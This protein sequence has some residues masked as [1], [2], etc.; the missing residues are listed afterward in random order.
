MK[1]SSFRAQSLGPITVSAGKP[2]VLF[3]YPADATPGC[4]KEACAFRDAWKSYE[5]RGVAIVGVSTDDVAAHARFAAE[6]HLPFPL[7]AD[8]DGA[9]ARAWGVGVTFGIAQRQTVLVDG[10]GVV[11]QTWADVDPGVHAAQILAA[12]PS[13][14]SPA[15][16]APPAPAPATVP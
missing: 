9:I 14:T 3:F 7:L 8:T 2:V 11:L 12:V 4:T 16:A 13:T 10:A 1:L 6:H 5:A 15:Q